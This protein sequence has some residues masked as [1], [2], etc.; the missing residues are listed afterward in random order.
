MIFS[1]RSWL[2]VEVHE[3]SGLDLL[4]IILLAQ[5]HQFFGERIDVEEIEVRLVCLLFRSCLLAALNVQIV[6]ME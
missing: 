1:V 5:C 2:T 3:Y 4:V 6:S